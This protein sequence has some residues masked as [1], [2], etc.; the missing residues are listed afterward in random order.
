M[1]QP[2]M[3]LSKPK[4]G[5]GGV[6]IQPGTA[7][8]VVDYRDGWNKVETMSEDKTRGWVSSRVGPELEPQLSVPRCDRKYVTYQPVEG[9]IFVGDP[10]PE[11]LN[12]GWLGDCFLM[13]GLGA[14]AWG[15]PESIRNAIREGDEEGTYIVTIDRVS[16]NGRN[17]G[18]REIKIDNVF[19]TKDGHLLYGQ[20]GKKAKDRYEIE[21]FENGDR[22]L[23]PAII[24]KAFATMLGGYDKLDQ[25]G[26]EAVVFE[27]LTGNDANEYD[28]GRDGTEDNKLAIDEFKRAIRKGL[29]VACSTKGHKVVTAPKVYDN[30][31]YIAVGYSKD[32]VILRNP[33]DARDTMALSYKDFS[34]AF[35]S[36]AV[37]NV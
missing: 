9:K 2:T 15:N 30:H 14:L 17:W 25:G 34:R 27:S 20:G 23:W 10:K 36:F 8:K 37:A 6:S 19:P 24:E 1:N 21:E 11:D 4:A 35:E 12:Q 16:D 29:P 5:A 3:L 7:L 31:V 32:K 18:K 22:P 26:M 13:G 28:I 33:H